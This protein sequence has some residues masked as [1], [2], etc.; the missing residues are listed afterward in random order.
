MLERFL[1]VTN[2]T[3]STTQYDLVETLEREKEVIEL[4]GKIAVN[5]DLG[6]GKTMVLRRIYKVDLVNGLI[7]ELEPSFVDM[8]IVL[9]EKGV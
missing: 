9:N 5:N 2:V 6:N 3:T 4:V 8:Q 1:V 7:K